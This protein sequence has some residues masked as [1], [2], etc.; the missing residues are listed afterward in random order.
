MTRN[1]FHILYLVHDLWDATVHKRIAMLRDGGAEVTVM[2][3]YRGD[4]FP[5]NYIH[6]CPVIILGKTYDG[7]FLHRILLTLWNVVKIRKYRAVFQQSDVVM[8]RTL[9]MLAIAVRGKPRTLV[10]ESLDIHRLLLKTGP[11][12]SALRWIEGWLSRRAKLLLTSSP[13]F[14]DCYFKPLSRVRLPSLVIANKVYVAS[15]VDQSPPPQR[16]TLSH[17]WKIGW[18]G[19]IRCRKSLDTLIQLVQSMKGQVEVIIRGKP[20]LDQFDDF[21]QMT[22]DVP[23][24]S[25]RGPYIKDDLARMYGEVH[26]TWAIDMFEEGLNSSWL[27]PNRI[28]EGGRYG[29]VPI[30]QSHVETGKALTQLGIGVLLNDPLRDNLDAFFRNLTEDQFLELQERSL[31]VPLPNWVATRNDSIQLVTT[32]KNLLDVHHA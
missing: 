26:F 6:D 17:P 31:S 19:A 20:A 27:L 21:Y 28:Y 23:G 22:S 5:P 18:F 29:S 10:Y 8:A 15:G 1:Q 2:G 11:I 12:G 7:Q 32:L 30:A 13:A 25:F 24:L 14:I 4:Q 9:E 3:F 16:P